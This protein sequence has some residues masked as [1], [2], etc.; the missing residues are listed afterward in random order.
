[1]RSKTGLFRQVAHM[2][3]IFFN[4]YYYIAV[5]MEEEFE[6]EFNA[7]YDDDGFFQNAT[8][9]NSTVEVRDH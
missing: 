8:L 2:R 6:N 9:I 1:M 3:S 5:Y 4:A 7:M